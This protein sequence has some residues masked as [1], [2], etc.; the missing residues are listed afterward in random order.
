[1]REENRV[2]GR[3]KPDAP[4]NKP[5]YL[6]LPGCVTPDDALN[7][8][9]LFWSYVARTDTPLLANQMWRLNRLMH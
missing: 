1:M 5:S 3:A 2:G 9:E 6:C 7:L 4:R 8:P